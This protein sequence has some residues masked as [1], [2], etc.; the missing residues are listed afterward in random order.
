ML[1]ALATVLFVPGAIFGL[2]GGALFGPLWG[3]LF[4]LAGATLGA[5]AAFLVS[6]FMSRTG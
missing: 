1:F 3:T 2:A 6:R 4:N 5:T